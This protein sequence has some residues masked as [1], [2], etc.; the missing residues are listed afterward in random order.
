MSRRKPPSGGGVWGRDISLPRDGGPGY[1]PG[2]F[3]KIEMQFGAI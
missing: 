2:K 1:Q 3:L